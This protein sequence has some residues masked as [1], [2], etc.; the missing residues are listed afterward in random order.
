MTG[1]TPEALAKIDR[2]RKRSIYTET[3]PAVT[4]MCFTLF[5][6]RIKG[7]DGRGQG[8]AR[9]EKV[10]VQSAGCPR[11]TRDSQSRIGASRGF[12]LS[13]TDSDIGVLEKP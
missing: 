5:R 7:G 1:G 10:N 11:P 8:E 3:I 12:L 13:V 4:F 6:K 2:P 9:F